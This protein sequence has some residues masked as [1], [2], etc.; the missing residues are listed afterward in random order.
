MADFLKRRRAERA[1]AAL[2]YSETKN[3]TLLDACTDAVFL[4][5]MAGRIV[6]CNP[7]A[8]RMFGYPRSKLLS[9][10]VSALVPPQTELL[11]QSIFQ[12]AAATG[13]CRREA[14]VRGK[15]GA[16]FWVAASLRQVT[17]A[18]E[19]LIAVFLRDITI[20]R[21]AERQLLVQRDL[22]LGLAASGS[23]HEAVRLCLDAAVEISGLDCGGI[24]VLEAETGDMVLVHSTGLGEGFVRAVSRYP[25]ESPE[26]SLIRTGATLLGVYGEDGLDR[27]AAAIGERVRAMVVIP[28]L[29]RGEAIACLNLGSHVKDGLSDAERQAAETIAAQMGHV[30]ARLQAQEALRKAET[31][32]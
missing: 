5:T 17:V 22:A 32:E 3:R 26:G 30:I 4:H 18:G 25:R 2:R 10:N 23:L 7:A 1:E 9:L 15:D 28:V 8:C 13:G 21:W 12:E 19:N 31:R 29:D 6:D 24:Y 11:L 20:S 14:E 27:S 16:V